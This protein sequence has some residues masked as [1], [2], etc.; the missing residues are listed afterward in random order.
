MDFNRLNHRLNTKLKLP[1]ISFEAK[2]T[3]TAEASRCLAKE[4]GSS[5]AASFLQQTISEAGD[6]VLPHIGRTKLWQVLTELNF[7]WEKS[8]QK[9]L[10]I[11]LEEIICWTRNYLRFIRK[12]RD[13]GRPIYYQEETWV[14]SDHSLTKMWSDKNISSSRQAFMEGWST[15]I[16]PPFGKDNRLIISHI[17]SE[18]EF[19]KYGL[20][21]FQSK[22]TKDYRDEMTTDVFEEYFEQMIEHIAPNSIIVLDN[23]PYHSQLLERLL[24]TAWKE[25]DILD[26]LRTKLVRCRRHVIEEEPKIMWD[27]DNIMDNL[28]STSKMQRLP[29]K[30]KKLTEAELLKLLE[31]DSDECVLSGSEYNQS[32]EEESDIEDASNTDSSLLDE[33]ARQS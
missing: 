12:F 13:K 9:S 25:Q 32:D 3:V 14:N 26:W 17:S 4:G 20:L 5:G 30:N 24:T 19:V 7:W 27:F 16:S 1:L 11:D 18:K 28:P 21:E 2:L 23:A 22:S 10:L 6:P 31:E 8:D 29:N 15:G 33:N